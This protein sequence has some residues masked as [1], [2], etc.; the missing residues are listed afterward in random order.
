MSVPEKNPLTPDRIGLLEPERNV[1]KCGLAVNQEGVPKRVT[2]KRPVKNRLLVSFWLL[3]LFLSGV[4]AQYYQATSQQFFGIAGSMERSI[5]FQYPVEIVDITVVEG[6]KVKRGELLL[7]VKR[8]DL[9]A[10]LSIV[11]DEISEIKVRK[12]ELTATTTAEVKRLEAEK[13]AAQSELD[14]QI[15][16]L[17]SRLVLN[18]QWSTHQSKSP[19]SA[20]VSSNNI[21]M[22]KLRGLQQQRKYSTSSYQATID[23]FRQQLSSRERPADVKLSVLV[24][25][26]QELERQMASL[27]VNSDFDG[28]VGSVL[29]TR[30]EQVPMFSP[31]MTL[32]G[33]ST[34]FVKAFI[35]EAVLNEVKIGQKVWVES[36][37]SG[38]DGAVLSG[39]VESLGNR[40]IEYPE[41]L[42]RSPLVSAWGREVIVELEQ[43]NDLLLGEKVVVILS[44]PKSWISA[45]NDISGL[46]DLVNIFFKAVYAESAFRKDGAI[47]KIKTKR[48]KSES[49]EAS[50]L[51]WDAVA[52]TYWLISD[53]SRSLFEF[54]HNGELLQ[55]M[56]IRGLELDDAESISMDK[57]SLYIA[58][59]V[60]S[61]KSGKM[62][63]K[64]K[65]LVK[66]KRDG[67]RWVYDRELDLHAVLVNLADSESNDGETRRFLAKALHDNSIDIE[68][69]QVIDD[70]LY[71]GFKSPSNSAGESVILKIGA[72]D[73]LFA[74]R[75][76]HAEIW[77]KLQ[78]FDANS[79][80]TMAISDMLIYS[81]RVYLTGVDTDAGKSNSGLWKLDYNRTQADQIASFVG[82]K[83]EG[84]AINRSTKEV[85]IVFD[86]GSKAD[87][88]YTHKPIP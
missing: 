50:G 42:K 47:H 9:A 20:G 67:E 64:R 88:Y 63:N 40:I 70:R 32:H 62:K 49:I 84:I 15:A 22:V 66:L 2:D 1:P 85:T 4:I 86:G 24:K 44:E 43:M 30:G 7:E 13:R 60:S 18:T 58:A 11:D 74:K 51:V 29:F 3:A 69:H 68:A 76:I 48:L 77:K 14:I 37:T 73:S 5:S 71:L 26:K 83:A 41:R 19:E 82:Y 38:K 17:E 8:F 27:T 87:S 28:S 39:R 36:L 21:L 12:S 46:S 35:H 65:K 81:N 6:S 59:S 56:E 53:E 25:R 31:I 79:R 72:L 55:K 75:P 80:R 61:N 23:N 52:Q 45:L 57:D 16:R 54:G 34:S 33:E 10:N 78:L